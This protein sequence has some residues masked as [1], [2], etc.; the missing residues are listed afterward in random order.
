MITIYNAQGTKIID[1]ANLEGSYCDRSIMG[2]STLQLV[3]K[4]D[5]PIDIPL[6]SY[7]EYEAR[8]YTLLYPASI[9]KHHTKDFECTLLF[10]GEEELLASCLIKDISG[11]IP[12]RVKFAITAK[13]I[14]FVRCIVDSLNEHYGGGWSVGNVIDATE[15]TLAFSHEYCL[16]AISRVAEVFNTEFSVDNKTLS[17]GKVSIMED[18]PLPMSY[19]NGKGFRPGTGRHNDGKKSAI[20]K[21]YVE[22]GSRNIDY[23]SYGA[24]VLLLPKSAV[25]EYNGRTYRTDEHGMYIT[26]DNA[27]GT[28]EDSYDGS[29]VYPMREGTVSEVIEEADGYDFTDTSIPESLNFNDYRIKGE[30]AVVVFQTGALTGREF[31][32]VQ[33]KDKLTGYIHA[34]RRFKLVSEEQDG[35][36][37]P[38]GNFV[39]KVGD[40]YAIYNITLPAEYLSN[41]SQRLFEEAVRYFDTVI[42][43]PYIFSGEVDPI[44]AKKEWLRIGGYMQPGGH[45]LFSDPQY[46][47][48]GS[49][50]RVTGVRTLLDKPYAPQLTLTN[51]PA[52]LSVS[53]ALSKLEADPIIAEERYKK[54]IRQLSQS[55][56][57]VNEAK[58]MI[59]EA[60]KDMGNSISAPTVNAMQMIVGDKFGQF[61][62]YEQGSSTIANPYP[63][64]FDK[65]KAQLSIRACDLQHYVFGADG[66]R[67]SAEIKGGR[68][69]LKRWSIT[70][71]TSPALPSAKAYYIYAVTKGDT[72]T[73]ELS[74]TPRASGEVKTATGYDYRFPVG[75]LTSVDRYT[76]MR[77][78]APLH[79]YTDITPGQ[80]VTDRIKSANDTVD[81]DLINEQFIIGDPAGDT[82]LAWI[83]GKLYIK[84]L[85]ITVGKGEKT[86]EQAI[87]DQN[88]K[89]EDIN[90]HQ[91]IIKNGTWWR[92]DGHQY[93]DTGEVA[94]GEKGDKGD[95]GISVSKVDAEFAVNTSATVA[96]T[97]GWQ[98]TAPTLSAGKQLWTRSKTTYSSGNPTYTTPVNITPMKGDTG[99]NGAAGTSVESITEE[100]AISDSKTVQPTT[101]WSATQPQ[102]SYGKYIWSRIK[103][104]YK[105]P[106]STYYTGYA[107]SSEWEAV[108]EMKVGGRNLMRTP[109]ATMQNTT[110]RQYKSDGKGNITWKQLTKGTQPIAFSIT[111]ALSVGANY[112]LQFKTDC[113]VD[114]LRKYIYYTGK[115]KHQKS[116]IE[117]EEIGNGW[118]QVYIKWIGSDN[119]DAG[120][121]LYW[122]GNNPND[123]ATYSYKDFKLELG[124]VATDW[125]EAPEDVEA[126]ITDA[127]TQADKALADAKAAQDRANDTYTKAAMDGIITAEEEQAIA[128]EALVAQM[129]NLYADDKAAEAI[130]T[131][132]VYADGKV[133]AEEQARTKAIS[134][135]AETTKAQ[136][137]AYAD[138]KVTAEEQAR[139]KAMQEAEA[140]AKAEY[141]RLQKAQ[142][143]IGAIGTGKPIIDNP[144][145]ADRENVLRLYSHRNIDVNTLEIIDRTDDNPVNSGFQLRYTYGGASA[146]PGLGGFSGRVKSRANGVFVVKIIA[147]IPKGYIIVDAS[148]AVGDNPTKTWL[149]SHDGTGDFETYY[150]AMECGST[151]TFSTFGYFY[152]YGKSGVA[153]T[154]DIAFYQVYDITDYYNTSKELQDAID[155]TNKSITDLQTNVTTSIRDGILDDAEKQSLRGQINLVSNERDQIIA[156]YNKVYVNPQL[157]GTAKTNLLNAKISY[158]GAVNKL[159]NTLNNLIAKSTAIDS[160]DRNTVNS[161]FSAVRSALVSLQIALDEANE[162]LRKVVEGKVD[163]VGKIVDT[164]DTNQ[165]PSWYREQ[166]MR[167]HYEFKKCAVIGLPDLTTPFCQ[168]TTNVKWPNTSGG[169]VTQK[170][171]TDTNKEYTRV[172]TSDDSAWEAW[173][174]VTDAIDAER[175]AREAE[176]KKLMDA[177]NIALAQAKLAYEK[178]MSAGRFHGMYGE[179]SPN[180]KYPYSEHETSV[181]LYKGVPY[182]LFGEHTAGVAPETE[183]GKK[184]WKGLSSMNALYAR[185]ILADFAQIG[186]MK[187]YNGVG[188][189]DY[190][191]FENKKADGN[192]HRYMQIGGAAKTEYEMLNAT[193]EIREFDIRDKTFTKVGTHILDQFD[194]A[195][196]NREVRYT[197][198]ITANAYAEAKIQ[199]S[200]DGN[201]TYM[202][203]ITNCTVTLILT[204]RK[205]D[206]TVRYTK[207]T[208]PLSVR[209][210]AEGYLGAIDHT[211]ELETKW[212]YDEQQKSLDFDLSIDGRYVSKLDRVSLEMKINGN[213]D[214]LYG[215]STNVV[216]YLPYDTSQ[217]LV[218]F[219]KNLM[220]L[221]FGRQRYILFN[222]FQDLVLK[223]VGNALFQGDLKVTGA[224][225]CDDN[226]SSGAVLAGAR[227]N[228]TGLSDIQ[229]GKY[230]DRV[231]YGKAMAVYGYN[232]KTFTVYHGIGHTNYIPMIT[233]NTQGW[234]DQPQ[235]TNVYANSFEVLF[236]NA[237]GDKHNYPF[238]YIAFL[239]K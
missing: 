38:G 48:E 221:F 207:S 16:G 124:T 179:F 126:R 108:N 69:P 157:A 210:H 36:V 162:Y 115:N 94:K 232:T 98:T 110:I 22:G 117:A 132:K 39:P 163:N 212:M 64:I 41:A 30:K 168:L 53:N 91:P 216:N 136:A 139:I 95:T 26:C 219:G 56:Q 200:Y 120:K 51:A 150:F 131:A 60:Y 145:F 93:V 42:N 206:G 49:V 228:A 223:V 112:I 105:D 88:K 27:V 234:A 193:T 227:F 12:Y 80:L 45:I 138:G 146:G 208:T 156:S 31:A 125:S 129:A 169:R 238:S 62:F 211:T 61:R 33:T 3:V 9:K 24:Q 171:V 199:Y 230:A 113:P 149:S 194:S 82:C 114:L 90:K 79:G 215:S 190:I 73:I 74:E 85:L 147:K 32:L 63:L 92:W 183:E 181:V 109:V 155:A 141:A 231:G 177:N 180:I 37:M 154:F 15:Q 188:S 167:S 224:F 133:S 161:Q 116:T 209:A 229:L 152:F 44:W 43:P 196:D 5:K 47:P 2:G 70:P 106:Q 71:W 46:H 237:N 34:E 103:I 72:C 66:T 4:S 55:W 127:K 204:V 99:G 104:V 164:R 8:R 89:V 214:R 86:I 205:T 187:L 151:G 14:D 173:S 111:T 213:G 128:R 11:G 178:S 65:D 174:S 121:S 21:L 20:G 58:E 189:D 13:P 159:I 97:T 83:G 185:H 50:I 158:E 225:K 35:F 107:C 54:T 192:I 201:D 143:L 236:R 123:G 135:Q 57:Q 195:E 222:Y 29:A 28:A 7:V 160:N 96:P 52:A 17:L 76:D 81:I 40:K 184:V 165:P 78:F 118:L 239:A 25:L 19:G 1:V 220:S 217:S 68:T 202:P 67:P 198:K 101:G 203:S 176:E 144:T 23:S 218:H 191:A 172:G 137:E 84:G 197:G 77:S 119:L 233:P 100:F 87:A 130:N 59:D 186:D 166:G 122:Y 170:A 142:T 140:N 75:I 134:A 226:Q 182:V 235:V 10:H 148:N 102:W 153:Q 6:N 175:Q 18:N